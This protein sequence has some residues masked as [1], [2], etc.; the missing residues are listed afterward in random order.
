MHFADCVLLNR[1]DAACHVWAQNFQKK[2]SELC[3]PCMFVSVK[4]GRVPNPLLVLFPEARRL[5]LVFDDIDPVDQLDLDEENL[6]EE[7]F[8]LENK[9]DPYFERLLS[10][11]RVKPVPDVTKYLAKP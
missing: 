8:T 2:F 11:H 7:P 6:P 4:K 3:Y 1:R 9:P 5:T 10:G